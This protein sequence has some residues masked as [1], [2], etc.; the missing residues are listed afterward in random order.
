MLQCY[1]SKTQISCGYLAW[2]VINFHN[3]FNSSLILFRTRE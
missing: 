1:S 3:P 2:M